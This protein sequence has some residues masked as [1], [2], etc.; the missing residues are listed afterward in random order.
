MDHYKTLG[1][2]KSASQEDIK[3]AYRK[4]ASKHHPD[5]GGDTKAFQ[6]IQVAYDVLSDPQKRSEY[7]NPQQE[8]FGFNGF[9]FGPDF[10]D[11]FGGRSPFG[12]NQRPVRRNRSISISVIVNLKEVL[13]GKDVIGSIRLPSGREQTLQLKIPKGV[14]NGDAIKYEGLGDDSLPNAPRGDLIVHIAEERDPRFTRN[15]ADLILEEQISVF[16]AILGTTLKVTTVDNKELEIKVPAGV[17]PGQMI[18]CNGYGVSKRNS[19]MRGNLLVKLNI[20][21]PKNIEE[22]DKQTIK[23]LSGK[24]GVR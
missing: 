6:E 8:S 20:F 19:N 16:D 4:L 3:K 21:I 22:Q 15:G 1:V 23:T 17:Q 13:E 10:A 24:Y 12:F 14:G 9:G 5:R 18:K 7:D 11:I 2:D